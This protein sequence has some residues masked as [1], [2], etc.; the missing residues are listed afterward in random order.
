MS[1][2]R[3]RYF[4]L[5]VYILSMAML[6]LSR[7]TN[8]HVLGAFLI[9][10]VLLGIA[11]FFLK[12]EREGEK[13]KVKKNRKT[14]Y[15]ALIFSSWFLVAIPLVLFGD[16]VAEKLDLGYEIGF[17]PNSLGNILLWISVMVSAFA[18]ELFFRRSIYGLFLKLVIRNLGRRYPRYALRF[19]FWI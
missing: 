19:I 8:F 13:V 12:A 2:Q 4:A 7:I 11:S 17:L 16:L 14:V 9:T 1:G 10:S 18:Y 15:S 5:M 6:I 3:K